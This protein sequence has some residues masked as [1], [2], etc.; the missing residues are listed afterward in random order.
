V[1][2]GLAHVTSD[3]TLGAHCLTSGNQI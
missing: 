2:N 3:Q 1:E